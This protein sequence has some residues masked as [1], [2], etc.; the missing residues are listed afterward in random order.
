MFDIDLIGRTL[1]PYTIVSKIGQGGMAVVYKAYETS[2]DRFVAIKVLPPSLAMETGFNARFERETKAIAKLDHPNI[3]P[4]YGYGNQEGL[5]YLIMR[6]VQAGTL[7]EKLHQPLEI[8]YIADI[9]KQI[10]K[11]LEYAHKSGVIHR[12]IKPSNILMADEHWPLLTDFG[13]AKMMESPSHLTGTGVGIGTP[14]YMSPE[15]AQGLEVDTRTDIYSL[16]IMLYEM[17]IGKVPYEAETPMAVALKHIN[18]PLPLPSQVKPDLPEAFENVILKALAKRPDDRFQKVFDLVA[19]LD[20]AVLQVA[21]VAGDAPAPGVEAAPTGV[22]EPISEPIGMNIQTRQPIAEE[23]TKVVVAPSPLPIEPRI[24][25]MEAKATSYPPQAAEEKKKRVIPRVW[26][27]GAG[28]TVVLLL[29]AVLIWSPWKT[30]PVAEKAHPTATIPLPTAAPTKPT[31]ILRMNSTSD[32]F[33]VAFSGGASVKSSKQVDASG[34][35]NDASRDHGTF[36]LNQNI[37]LAYIGHLV[38]VTHEVILSN[39]DTMDKMKLSIDGGCLGTSEV[40]ILNAQVEPPVVVYRYSMIGCQGISLSFSTELLRT[41]LPSEADRVGPPLPT[42]PASMDLSGSKLIDSCPNQQTPNRQL[43]MI[44]FN[45]GQQEQITSDF[46][47]Y[48]LGWGHGWTPDGR[49]IYYFARTTSSSPWTT[50]I[51]NAD[52]TGKKMLVESTHTTFSPDGQVVAY[53]S[54]CMV[55][56]LMKPDGTERRVLQTPGLHCM[57]YLRW[58][59]D[60]AQLAFAELFDME[61]KAPSIWVINRDGSGLQK[62]L[63]FA[64]PIWSLSGLTWSPDGKSVGI[65]YMEKEGDGDIGF[66][67]NAIT[68]SDPQPIDWNMPAWWTPA[69]WPQWGIK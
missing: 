53:T 35:P 42:L 19:A 65:W 63:Q 43:C 41:T 51:M 33:T 4:V 36:H 52:G 62:I 67:L 30:L 18:A 38:S 45:S 50:Y 39:V 48:D 56:R 12:D 1:G 3:L 44:R 27:I 68:P 34:N 22:D 60:S 15:Q 20:A 8:A 23:P 57:N 16:G 64:T 47:Y 17:V 46:N 69:F 10:G 2:L 31:F 61:H 11:A 59:P 14:A 66:L 21:K 5:S 13:L 29:L 9:I 54:D 49:Q 37:N 7:K 24:E 28:V 25:S 58:S 26:W 32:W 6:F 55:L 40:E